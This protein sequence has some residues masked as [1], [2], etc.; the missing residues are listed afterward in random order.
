MVKIKSELVNEDYPKP[1]PISKLLKYLY[2]SLID[3]TET[4]KKTFDPIVSSSATNK[5]L[6][7]YASES[8]VVLSTLI[9]IF[10]P[11]VAAGTLSNEVN[12]IK[13]CLHNMILEENDPQKEQQIQ[14]LINY[15]DARPFKFNV[16]G[17]VPMD[18]SLPMS[19]LNLY[20]TYVIVLLQLTHLY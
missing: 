16:L 14:K 3:S 20:I 4:V 15:M 2:K 5:G 8:A 18:A 7:G 13:V 17:V 9:V 1:K 19:V 12:Q 10:A 11:V 6:S